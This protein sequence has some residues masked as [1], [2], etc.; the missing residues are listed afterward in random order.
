MY[1]TELPCQLTTVLPSNY[2]RHWLLILPHIQNSRMWISANLELSGI[3]WNHLKLSGIVW[4]SFCSLLIISRMP[5]MT[6]AFN[7]KVSVH[8]SHIFMRILTT[9]RSQ[10]SRQQ[11]LPYLLLTWLIE[12]ESGPTHSKA[13]EFSIPPKFILYFYKNSQ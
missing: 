6:D 1:C 13:V 8:F 2:L 4:K 7:G 3:I 9:Y 11:S 10:L 12:W 5:V